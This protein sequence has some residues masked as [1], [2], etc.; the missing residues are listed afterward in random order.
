MHLFKLFRVTIYFLCAAISFFTPIL[1]SAVSGPLVLYTFDEGIGSIVHDVSGNGTPLNLKI[2]NAENTHWLPGGGLSVD[3]P[4]SII[5]LASPTKIV[6]GIKKSNA[7]TIEA[8][9]QPAQETQSGPARIATLSNGTL[10]RNFTLGQDNASYDVRLRST[11]TGEN[12]RPSLSSTDNTRNIKLTHVVYTRNANGR[13]KIFVNGVRKSRT[14]VSGDLSNWSNTFTFVLAN[15]TS[16]DRPWLGRFHRFAVYNRALGKSEIVRNFN[17]GAGIK[18]AQ[19]SPL[20]LYT[21]GEGSGSIVH[22]YS[23]VGTPLDLNIGDPAKTNWLAGGGL[24]VNKATIITGAGSGKIINALKASNA[25]TIE[26]WLNPADIMQDGPARIV[27]LSSDTLNRDFTLGQREAV[28][29]VRLRSTATNT[30]GNP[31]LTS[32]SGILGT[33]LTHV[34]YTRGKNGVAML[35][36]NGNKQSQTTVGGDFSEWDINHEFALANELTEDRPWRG[37]FYFVAVYDRALSATDVD[38]HFAQGAYREIPVDM[39]TDTS[40]STETTTS[41]PTGSTG[42]GTTDTAPQLGSTTLNWLAPVTRG[43]GTPLSISEIAGYTLYYGESAGDLSNS[44]TI[45][46]A[47]TTS[48]TVTDLPLGVYYFVVTA[49]DTAGLESADSNTATKIVD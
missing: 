23:G 12:G 48:V 29:D 40:T 10:K 4:A 32:P 35:Y 46:D 8:W 21:F 42:G 37:E 45:D 25:M 31:S 38:D 18:P 41:E 13:A 43:D 16:D 20:V 33:A 34:I 22:D 3:Q 15:E 24:S 39:V 19:N 11:E 26:A 9:I 17:A 5:A 44:I 2:Y 7:I 47:Y 27:T 49:H 28:Y 6:D 14:T 30:N 36:I 1:A